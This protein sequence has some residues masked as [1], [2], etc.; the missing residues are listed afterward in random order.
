VNLIYKDAPQELLLKLSICHK[1]CYL[2]MNIPKLRHP[3]DLLLH[4]L[5]KAFCEAF[6]FSALLL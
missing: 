4:H 5:S 3:V 6:S 2:K 1:K